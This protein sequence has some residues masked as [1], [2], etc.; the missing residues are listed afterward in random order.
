L[1]ANAKAAARAAHLGETPTFVLARGGREVKRVVGTGDL[2]GPI[3]GVL[4]GP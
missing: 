1:L 2:S 4:A 3:D